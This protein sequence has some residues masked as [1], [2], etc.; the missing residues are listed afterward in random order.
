MQK[1]ALQEQERAMCILSEMESANFLGCLLAHE[2]EILLALRDDPVAADHFVRLANQFSGPITKSVLDATLNPFCKSDRS[3]AER[4]TSH[5]ASPRAR[6]TAPSYLE[7]RGYSRTEADKIEDR[8]CNQIRQRQAAKAPRVYTSKKCHRCR[9][10]G[11]IRAQCRT[12]V[13]KRT[14]CK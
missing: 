6:K 2:D 11:H 13:R 14:T 3:L 5:A 8:L 9:Q 12:I 7:V 4:P 10:V 1:D